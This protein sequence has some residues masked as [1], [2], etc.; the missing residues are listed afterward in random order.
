MRCLNCWDNKK[1]WGAKSGPLTH[2][3]AVKHLMD[4]SIHILEKNNLLMY[5][6]LELFLKYYNYNKYVIKNIRK[7]EKQQT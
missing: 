5:K 7:N 1:F 3:S 6:G 4:S 2:A